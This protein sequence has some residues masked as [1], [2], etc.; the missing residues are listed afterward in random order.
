MSAVLEAGAEAGVKVM[1]NYVHPSSAGKIH[2]QFNMG[3]ST[4]VFDP[5]EVR[6]H[7]G[8]ARDWDLETDA[9]ALVRSPAPDIDYYDEDEAKRVYWPQTVAMLKE[10]TGADHVVMFNG[11]ARTEGENPRSARAPARNPH[12]DFNEASYH[13]FACEAL[14]EEEA[15]RRLKGRFM[16]V[17][18]W[19][20]IKTVEATPLALC[21]SSTVAPED[22]IQGML[23]KAKGEPLSPV[24]GYN[25]AHNPAHRWWY[26]PRL[27]PDEALVFK[28]CDSDHSRSQWTPHTAIDDPTVRAGA[29]P[30]ESYEC[31]AIC[32]WNP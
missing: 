13:I 20:P 32:F 2:Y 9:L 12:V 30:R 23:A 7:D 18:I 22:L 26:F 6:V 4:L 17:N 31:R 11:V 25:L 29:P 5:H 8:R 21:Q 27:K 24:Q 28:I 15:E 3:D 19:R 14:G 16:G 1:L 10:L